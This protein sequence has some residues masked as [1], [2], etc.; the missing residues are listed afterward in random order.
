[1]GLKW[2]R[3]AK[4]VRLK[5]TSADHLWPGHS[6]RGLRNRHCWRLGHPQVVLSA[7]VFEIDPL[8]LSWQVFSAAFFFGFLLWEL[9]YRPPLRLMSGLGVL[10][11]L[12]FFALLLLGVGWIIVKVL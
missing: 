8:S 9:M 3:N 5:I 10:A 4:S 7:L 1:M 2:R 12:P 6:L 11:M